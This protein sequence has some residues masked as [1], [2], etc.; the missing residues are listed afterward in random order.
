MEFLL[1]LTPIGNQ[2]IN[3][4]SLAKYS[5]RENTEVCRSEKD[6]FGY[7]ERSKNEF[8]I[9]TSNIKKGGWSLKHYVN[10]TVYH[11]AVHVAQD[12]KNRGIRSIFGN[13]TLGISKKSMPLSSDK[14]NEVN[15]SA[16]IFSFGSRDREHEAYFL[17]DKPKKVLHYVQKY[18]F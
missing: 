4:L 2:I 13:S 10:E 5:I 6:V 3:S 15:Q 18:C 12:C 8:V 16:T 14:L 11:E 1:Y 17:E 9:C 7:L